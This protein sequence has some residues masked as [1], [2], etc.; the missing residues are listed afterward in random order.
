MPLRKAN[1]ITEAESARTPRKKRTPKKLS[2]LSVR[3]RKW[4]WPVVIV[5]FFSISVVVVLAWWVS[6]FNAGFHTDDTL[7]NLLVFNVGTTVE[8]HFDPRLEVVLVSQAPPTKDSSASTPS[9][10][11]SVPNALSEVP[12]GPINPAHR[13]YFAGLLNT[14]AGVHPKMVVFDIA[15]SK[16]AQDKEIDREFA[17]AIETLQ[18]SGTEVLVG[19]DLAGRG[20]ENNY[21]FSGARGFP[22][23][24]LSR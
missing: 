24:S 20:R 17:Q 4:R 16:D 3:L 8:N 13:H 1:G 14:L 11:A 23:Y 15:F 12:S 21:T 10:D 5:L 18:K 9:T 6:L 2:N 22:T 19:A 7:K